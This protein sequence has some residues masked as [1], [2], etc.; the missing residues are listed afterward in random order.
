MELNVWF[1]LYVVYSMDERTK[2][3]NRMTGPMGGNTICTYEPPG[4]M[5]IKNLE[6]CPLS[7]IRRNLF[8]NKR[9]VSQMDSLAIH[10]ACNSN[11]I[12][13]RKSIWDCAVMGIIKLESTEILYPKSSSNGNAT[14]CPTDG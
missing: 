8:T 9:Y 5:K 3:P 12:L 13:V 7:G 1:S 14:A 6:L 10:N 2:F 4:T 11:Y